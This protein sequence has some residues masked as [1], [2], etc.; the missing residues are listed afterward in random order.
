MVMRLNMNGSG[1]FMENFQFVVITVSPGMNVC[2][3]TKVC[4]SEK[5]DL[6]EE[7]SIRQL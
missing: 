2:C 4:D 1:C 6:I 7:G 5:V 3:G